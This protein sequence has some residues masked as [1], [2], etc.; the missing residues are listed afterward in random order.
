MARPEPTTSLPRAGSFLALAELPRGRKGANIRRPPGSKFLSPEHEYVETPPPGIG[1]YE[2]AE[3]W[4]VPLRSL[5]RWASGKKRRLQPDGSVKVEPEG[6]K[7]WTLKRLEFWTEVDRARR[8][9][10]GKAASAEASK[11]SEAVAVMRRDAPVKQAKLGSALQGW[12][13]QRMSRAGKTVKNPD[14]STITYPELNELEAM[15]LGTLARSG[16]EIER[17][18]LGLDLPAD[19]DKGT[20]VTPEQLRQNLAEMFGIAAPL[21]PEGEDGS[22]P[23]DPP[24]LDPPGEPKGT[25]SDGD[26]DED[27]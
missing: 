3:K 12:V 2:L 19:N 26:G 4:S 1:F 5:A 22:E 25:G 18:A 14:G 7:S 10:A 23:W 16:V 11:Q 15:R 13:V 24:R 8:E 21:P 9:A 17:I 27:D 20:L 6:D